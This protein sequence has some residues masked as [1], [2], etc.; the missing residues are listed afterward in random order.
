MGARDEVVR[1]VIASLS[2]DRGDPEAWKRLYQTLWPFVYASA[3]RA[4]GG[5]REW[6]QDAAQDVFL[7]LLRYADFEK[8][9]D[10]AAFYAYVRAICLNVSRS[11]LKTVTHQRSLDEI[12]GLQSASDASHALSEF[13]R[14]LNEDEQELLQLLLEGFALS[15]IAGKLQVSYSA[16]AVRVHRLR[17]KL[18]EL[19]GSAKSAR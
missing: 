19:S 17:L 14:D 15:G 4:L 7:K 3:F 5:S 12:P 13:S 18:L 6:S 2:Q 8:L 11:Y 16:A 1:D 10:P 9:Q